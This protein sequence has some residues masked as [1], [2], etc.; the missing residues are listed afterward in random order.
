MPLK[1]KG[2]AINNCHQGN[3]CKCGFSWANCT[4]TLVMGTAQLNLS[5]RTKQMLFVL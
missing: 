4:V 1:M 3:R 5:N 2:S